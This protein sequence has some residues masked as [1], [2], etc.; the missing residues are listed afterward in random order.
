MLFT[1]SAKMISINVKNVDTKTYVQSWIIG[2]WFVWFVLMFAWMWTWI[3]ETFNKKKIK[4]SSTFHGNEKS[5]EPSRKLIEI[6]KSSMYIR[7]TPAFIDPYDLKEKKYSHLI[8]ENNKSTDTLDPS[9]NTGVL[10][11]QIRAKNKTLSTEFE[12]SNV[13]KDKLSLEGSI[14][15]IY[16]I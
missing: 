4:E 11:S 1:I 8:L 13:Q 6:T 2:L 10:F 16:K 12:Y 3:F 9:F 5:P 15:V 7:D 14:Q